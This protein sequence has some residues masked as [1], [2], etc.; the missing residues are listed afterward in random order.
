MDTKSE[1]DNEADIEPKSTN[2]NNNNNNG[3]G[4][5][6]VKNEAKDLRIELERKDA[7]LRELHMAKLSLQVR[8]LSKMSYAKIELF[9]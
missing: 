7:E 6:E 9:S 1:D 2:N 3:G 8:S 5:I 4:L